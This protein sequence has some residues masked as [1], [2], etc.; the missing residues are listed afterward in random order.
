M[1]ESKSCLR[2]KFLLHK[3]CAQSTLVPK[4]KT[5]W[6]N[7]NELKTIFDHMQ[8]RTCAELGLLVL[9]I[10]HMQTNSSF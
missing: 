6:L 9:H 4:N 1:T 10:I 5:L 2:N 8:Q 7:V 3:S